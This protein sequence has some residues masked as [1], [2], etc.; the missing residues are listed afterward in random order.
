MSQSAPALYS[1]SF[2]AA[3]GCDSIS[4]IT[5]SVVSVS[6]ATV[7]PQACIS[8][9]SPSGKTF[10]V[11]GVY[12]D[13]IANAATCDSIISVNLS[14]DSALITSGNETICAGASISIHGTNQSAAGVYTGS[15]TAVNGCDSTSSIT[16]SVTA[17]VTQTA[18]A[19][20]CNGNSIVIYGTPRSAE[21]TYNDTIQSAGGCDSI[22]QS[23]TLT[24]LPAPTASPGTSYQINPGEIKN[25]QE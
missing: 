22:I 4:D 17:V 7:A 24:F 15:F 23:T 11:T 6:S 20:V 2:T 8:Y 21:G 3:N 1:S 12:A 14:I 19:N 13:T 16:L 18:S 10:T 9:T 5:L 25:S